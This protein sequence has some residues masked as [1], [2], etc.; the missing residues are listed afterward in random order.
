MIY[1]QTKMQ[2]LGYSILIYMLIDLVIFIINVFA[3]TGDNPRG[4]S[5]DGWISGI[6]LIN[7]YNK[8]PEC[9]DPKSDS[10][11]KT[12]GIY[13]SYA[14]MGNDGIKNKCLYEDQINKVVEDIKTNYIIHGYT[15]IQLLAYVII[16][17]L[18]VQSIGWWLVSTRAS[19][20]EWTFWILIITLI[21]TG[22]T[23]VVQETSGIDL[24]PS[25]PSCLDHVTSSLGFNTGDE[26]TYSFMARKDDGTKCFIEGTYLGTPEGGVESP[27]NP[28]VY[29]GD[30]NGCS[31][32]ALPLY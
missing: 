8:P 6:L 5:G 26:L 17:A 10:P 28:P 29:N 27:T 22:L 30:V 32:D 23:T 19:K 11:V 25:Q 9:S 14:T 16:P 4:C 21:Y 1:G 7:S 15:A 13:S 3:N 24:V 2:L 12:V 20:A 31:S 18:T